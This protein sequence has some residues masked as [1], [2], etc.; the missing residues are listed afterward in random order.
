MH[1]VYVYIRHMRDTSH[2][3]A[4]TERLSRQRARLSE[5]PNDAL[6]AIWV[7][8]TEKELANEYEHLGMVPGAELP[9]MSADELLAELMA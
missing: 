3:V 5:S 8:Q 9:T 6:L 4:I 2:L 1:I 7:C